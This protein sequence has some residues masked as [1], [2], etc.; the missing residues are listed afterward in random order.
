MIGK[1]AGLNYVSAV[2]DKAVLRKH[3]VRVAQKL[4]PPAAY[5]ICVLCVRKNGKGGVIRRVLRHFKYCRLGVH[6]AFVSYLIQ[7]LLP[8]FEIGGLGIVFVPYRVICRAVFNLSVNSMGTLKQRIVG[9][10]VSQYGSSC[11]LRLPC[12]SEASAVLFKE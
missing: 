5:G 11:G 9:I 10:G 8:G 7:H 12:D 6:S 1:N 2:D 3:F 4:F